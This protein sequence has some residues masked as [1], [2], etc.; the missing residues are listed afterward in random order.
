MER[1]ELRQERTD[2]MIRSN[3]A[4]WCVTLSPREAKLA[5]LDCGG[6][7]RAR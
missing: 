7:D 1:L 4:A 6:V 3:N 5:Q 2:L